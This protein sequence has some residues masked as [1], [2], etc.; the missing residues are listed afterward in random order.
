MR[1]EAIS[2]STAMSFT[3]LSL[4]SMR[5]FAVRSSSRA[6]LRSTRWK[7]ESMVSTRKFVYWWSSRLSAVAARRLIS[8]GSHFGFASGFSFSSAFD[9][10]RT[11][12]R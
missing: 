11:A 8:L 1:S 9:G 3:S 10:L 2:S 5:R 4:S 12:S 7:N 6:R